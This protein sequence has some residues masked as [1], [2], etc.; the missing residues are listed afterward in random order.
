MIQWQPSRQTSQQ[1]AW[2]QTPLAF[3]MSTS[4]CH[5]V[6][7]GDQEG[8]AVAMLRSQ[9]RADCSLWGSVD[10]YSSGQTS[11]P[12]FLL[13]LSSS[14][15]CGV[16]R[17]NREPTCSSSSGVRQVQALFTMSTSTSV[18]TVHKP[19]LRLATCR[20]PLSLSSAQGGKT[21]EPLLILGA[22]NLHDCLA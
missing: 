14:V 16:E 2:S 10:S 22:R 20:C 17:S 11:G 21:T 19:A 1:P 18:L 15:S 5:T 6:A 8:T 12:G 3:P 13:S 7:S 4:I 9:L